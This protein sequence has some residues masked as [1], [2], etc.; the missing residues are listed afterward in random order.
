[1]AEPDTRGEGGLL[2]LMLFSS[3][4]FAWNLLHLLLDLL[5]WPLRHVVFKLCLMRF[6]RRSYIDYRTYLRYPQKIAIGDDVWIN[7]GCRL[8]ASHGVKDAVIRIGNHVAVGPDVCFFG[9]GH[10]IRDRRL[11]DTAASIVVD[12]YCWIG[13]RAILLP[14]V[15][16]GEGAVVA[17]GSVVTRD[18]PAWTVVA[19]VP[20]RAIKARRLAEAG[21]GGTAP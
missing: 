18:V 4:A 19:G 16:V 20:A 7:R 8:F 10:D 12:D 11:P 6:G 2:P 15:H 5:P 1:M 17:A 21:D 9:A 3:H 14:G 13:G